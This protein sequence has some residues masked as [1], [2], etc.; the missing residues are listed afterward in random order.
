[1]FYIQLSLILSFLSPSSF[2]QGAPKAAFGSFTGFKTTT[3]TAA[4]PFSFLTNTAGVTNTKLARDVA[5]NTV[6]PSNGSAEANGTDSKDSAISKSETVSKDTETKESANKNEDGKI[7][8]KSN[9][10]YAKLKGLNESVTHWI[11]SHVD[12]NPFCILTPIFEDY[13]KYLKEIE[14]K[15]GQGKT[16]STTAEQQDKSGQKSTLK[17]FTAKSEGNCTLAG[18]ESRPEKSIFGTQSSASASSKTESS[19]FGNVNIGKSIF[20]NTETTGEG[21]TMFGSIAGERNPFTNT[22][23]TALED[24]K[25][26]KSGSEN[27]EKKPTAGISFSQS[28]PTATFSFGQSSAASTASAGFSFGG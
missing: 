14:A 22:P 11:K 16:E 9:D 13:E 6:N 24:K 10:Y 19:I 27:N 21:K 26:E 2:F 28:G 25:T 12:S 8:K 1:M 5:G 4:S 15:H 17:S 20:G 3:A 18:V 23:F 7:L